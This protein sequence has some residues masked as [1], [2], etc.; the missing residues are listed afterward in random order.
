MKSYFIII[1][2]L[3]PYIIHINNSIPKIEVKGF[4]QIPYTL[5]TI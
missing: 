2:F 5:N 1:I 4:K 3:F